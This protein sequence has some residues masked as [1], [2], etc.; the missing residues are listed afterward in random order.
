MKPTAAIHFDTR[1]TKGTGKCPL[2]IRITF[3]RERKYYKTGY[4]VSPEEWD[5]MNGLKPR[6]EIKDIRDKTTSL[7]KEVEAIIDGL[8]TFSFHEFEHQYHRK[9]VKPLELVEAFTQYINELEGQGR[10]GT[11]ASYRCSMVSLA[12]YNK[13]VKLTEISREYLNGYEQMMLKK[14]NSLTTIGIYLRSLRAIINNAIQEGHMKPEQYPFGRRKYVIPGSKNIKKAL[15]LEDISK[16]YYYPA[17]P[18]EAEDKARDFWIFSYLASGMNF[19]DI[20]LLRGSNIQQDFIVFHRAKTARTKRSN[21]VPIVVVL[22]D[23]LRRIISKWGNVNSKPDEYIFPVLSAEMTDYVKRDKIKQ[24][25]KNTNKWLN[26]ICLKIG[27]TNRV[28]TYAARHSFSTILKNSG[29]PIDYIKDSLG[30]SSTATTESYLSTYP[31]AVKR[32]F[33]E[34]LTVFKEVS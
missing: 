16:L 34:L 32:K 28:T 8:N 21:P 27:I 2:K 19:K 25:T 4:D 15:T 5:K 17:V 13:R 29:T 11:A 14:G 24:F 18:N 33:S 1:R 30:H 20:C 7:L 26:R 3:Q 9:S 23:D 10:V 22:N 6:K 31:D 12:E